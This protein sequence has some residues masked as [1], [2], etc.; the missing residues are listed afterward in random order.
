M[1]GGPSK[2]WAVKYLGIP[3][4]WVPAAHVLDWQVGSGGRQCPLTPPGQ[5]SRMPLPDPSEI[6]LVPMRSISPVY[7]YSATGLHRLD[8]SHFPTC[9]FPPLLLSRVML[10]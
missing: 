10:S 8:I 1:I 2:P 7:L 4:P 5:S 3:V 9:L 6:D